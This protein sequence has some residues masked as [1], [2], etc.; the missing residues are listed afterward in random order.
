MPRRVE[1]PHPWRSALIIFAVFIVLA[2]VTAVIIRFAFTPYEFIDNL[3][4]Q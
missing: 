1:R 3:P 4:S 2:L